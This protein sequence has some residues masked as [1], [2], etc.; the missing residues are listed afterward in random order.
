[1]VF[2]IMRPFLMFG[3]EF[4][5]F[6]SMLALFFLLFL[7]DDAVVILLAGLY[8][9]RMCRS[10]TQSQGSYSHQ[11]FWKIPILHQLLAFF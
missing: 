9:M 10:I 2:E 11:T 7:F 4:Y 1:M 8:G 5:L 3:I 6:H